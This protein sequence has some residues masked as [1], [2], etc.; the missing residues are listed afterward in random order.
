[1]NENRKMAKCGWLNGLGM[2]L[3]LWCSGCSTPQ[4]DIPPE[5]FPA[6]QPPQVVLAPGDEIEIKF[7]YN[8]DLNDRQFIRPDGKIALQ[9]I[10]ELNA[11]GKTPEELQ[12]MI[13]E[14][15][16]LFVDQPEVTVF[17]RA[18]NSRRVFVAGAVNSPQAVEVPGTLTVLGALMQAGGVNLQEAEVGNIVVIRFEE[19]QPNGW[20]LNLDRALQGHP[21]Q[22]FYLQPQD[23]VYVPR[24]KIV[25]ANQW[26]EQHISNMIPQVGLPIFFDIN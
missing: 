14:L 16:A 8:P 12:Y 15:A 7:F 6:P 25:D 10:G 3:V 20:L 11:A 26:L 18:L 5:A 13:R 19:G 9:L 17:V 2:A 22:P 24:T 1:M 21:Y 23:I 4:P